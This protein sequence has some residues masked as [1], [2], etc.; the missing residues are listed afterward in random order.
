MLDYQRKFSHA[1]P[2]GAMAKIER[3]T[4]GLGFAG[5][6]WQHP[7]TPAPSVGTRIPEGDM[8]K[9]R[10]GVWVEWNNGGQTLTGQVWAQDTGRNWFVVTDDQ[11]AHSVN[12]R[13]FKIVAP[14]YGDPL[15][16]D[17]WIIAGTPGNYT[18]HHGPSGKTMGG[19]TVR[20]KAMAKEVLAM[21]DGI[22]LG[23]NADTRALPVDQYAQ[24]KKAAEHGRHLQSGYACKACA[25]RS[26]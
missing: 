13:H 9:V 15:P 16:L 25:K 3:N 11:K 6:P 21:L 12:E 2:R 14:V 19:W 20:T 23:E 26:A 7:L 10:V 1:V 24:V 8:S 18:V 17:E 5:K 4:S 22:V